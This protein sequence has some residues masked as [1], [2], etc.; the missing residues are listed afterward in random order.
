MLVI[1]HALCQHFDSVSEHDGVVQEI[2]REA[3]DVQE[4]AE[5]SF[6][7]HLAD[8]PTTELAWLQDLHNS[9]LGKVTHPSLSP[10]PPGLTTR[11]H[12]LSIFQGSVHEL[13]IEAGSGCAKMAMAW[14]LDGAHNGVGPTK[15][16]SSPFKLRAGNLVFTGKQMP[17]CEHYQV[18]TRAD[19]LDYGRWEGWQWSQSINTAAGMLRQWSGVRCSARRAASLVMSGN[20][21]WPLAPVKPT[22]AAFSTRY[23]FSLCCSRL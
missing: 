6:G 18:L 14:V 9:T 11:C 15:A 16:A 22:W 1:T 12:I 3:A 20:C 19:R 2:V 21:S 7:E 13:V 10:G 4:L 5:E 17:L 23:C 8:Y